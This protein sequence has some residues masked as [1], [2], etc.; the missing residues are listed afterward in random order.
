MEPME[1]NR[2]VSSPT[3][4]AMTSLQPAIPIHLPAASST[5]RHANGR[6]GQSSEGERFDVSEDV[7]QSRSAIR[8]TIDHFAP[9]TGWLRCFLWLRHGGS[10]S[11]PQ[12]VRGLDLHERTRPLSS[13]SSGSGRGHRGI[14]EELSERGPGPPTP[15]PSLSSLSGPRPP[16]SQERKSTARLWIAIWRCAG[17]ISWLRRQQPD[18]AHSWAARDGGAAVFSD[19]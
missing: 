5:G 10:P 9:P 19:T 6:H 8:A 16:S 11:S 3:L 14:L 13:L 2:G 12:S 1:R 18:R 7:R 4:S 17:V 15:P